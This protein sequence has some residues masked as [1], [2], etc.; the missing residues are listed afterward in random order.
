MKTTINWRPYPEQKPGK[1][2]VY[3]VLYDD[4]EEGD[5]TVL[6]YGAEEDSWW[7]YDVAS[8]KPDYEFDHSQYVLGFAERSDITTEPTRRNGEREEA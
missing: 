3:S 5:V 7:S 6:F 1:Q 4:D 2:G 8:G